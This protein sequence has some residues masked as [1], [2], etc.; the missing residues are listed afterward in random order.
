[1]K[2]YESFGTFDDAK[3][4]FNLAVQT[5]II[6]FDE[7]EI[8]KYYDISNADRF[9]IV[10]ILQTKLGNDNDLSM[11]K[12][13]CACMVTDVELSD[14]DQSYRTNEDRDI[15]DV[16]AGDKIEVFVHHAIG[17]DP[18]TNRDDDQNIK[19]YKSGVLPLS[20]KPRGSRPAVGGRGIMK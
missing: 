5:T 16:K 11:C 6:G 15:N 18:K 10:A 12:P 13:N 3:K 19:D 1:M 7:Y 4:E 20:L 14:I 2:V 8:T 17:F 9:A